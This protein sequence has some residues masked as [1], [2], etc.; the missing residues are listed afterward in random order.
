MALKDDIKKIR[1][2]NGYTQS[3]MADMLNVSRSTLSKWETGNAI[4]TAD[5]LRNIKGMFQVSIDN[6]LDNS[7]EE[8]FESGKETNN[9]SNHS[10]CL[11]LLSLV[12]GMSAV[13]LLFDISTIL[14]MLGNYLPVGLRTILGIVRDASVFVAILIWIYRLLRKQGDVN[15]AVSTV[16]VFYICFIVCTI[17]ELYFVNSIQL[18]TGSFYIYTILRWAV[19]PIVCM[20]SIVLFYKRNEWTNPAVVVLICG[21]K[22]LENIY[23]V[24]KTV[25]S[26]RNRLLFFDYEFVSLMVD[27]LFVT[28][29]FILFLYY[30]L[31]LVKERKVRN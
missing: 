10:F 25:Y 17:H 23:G 11:I 14:T 20:V 13:K 31:V 7:T 28:L 1:M 12:F 19:L 22:L 5:D 21:T 8:L 6:L 26:N 16:I 24:T 9:I 29:L 2:D 30:A 18:A 15:N 27:S 3:E 4:P